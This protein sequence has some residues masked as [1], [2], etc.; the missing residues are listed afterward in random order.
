L[1]NKY[2]SQAQ[3]VGFF[4]QFSEWKI[5]DKPDVRSEMRVQTSS[6]G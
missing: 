5:S 4:A 1:Y 6:D 3:K 2:E